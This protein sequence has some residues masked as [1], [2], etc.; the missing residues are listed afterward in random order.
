MSNQELAYTI[1]CNGK[2]L[3]DSFQLVS[4]SVQLGLN[5]IGKA[6]LAFNAGSMDK[7]TFDEIDTDAFKPG[8][9][10][11]LDVGE[12]NRLKTLFEGVITEVGIRIT[13]DARSQMVVE[14]RD[15]LYAATLTRR[16]RIFTQKKDC[17]I[18]KEL[19]STYAAVAVDNTSYQHPELVQY[20]C[21]DW[22]FARRRAD[23][24]GMYIT[25]QGKNIVVA[26]PK[27][28]DPSVLTV[29]HGV[30]LIS[31]DVKLSGSHLAAKY[32]AVS[33]NPDT[34]T[35]DKAS[36]SE[37]TLNQQG[38]LS[39]TVIAAADNLLLQ[40]DAPIPSAALQAWAD[41]RALLAGL[42][43]YQG[44]FECYGA[45]EAKPGCLIELKGL[46]QRFNGQVFAGTVYHTIQNNEWTTQ[47]GVG[48]PVDDEVCEKK[49]TDAFA[50]E[51]AGLHIAT[52]KQLQGDPANGYRIQITLPWLTGNE[53]NL[54][55]RFATLY[56]TA[57]SDTF[58]LPEPGDEVVVGFIDS[59]PA[60]PVVLGCLP[61][62]K[63]KPSAEYDAKNNRKALVTRSKLTVEFDEEKKSIAVYTPAGNRI[64]L[65]DSDK[66]ICLS[67]Q[68]NNAI[69]MNSNGITL[70]SAKDIQLKAQG[71]LTA[72][73]TG[74]AKLTTKANLALEGMT[75]KGNAKTQ[76]ELKGTVKAE[77]SASAQTI[78]KGAMVMIN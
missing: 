74:D 9:T 60:Y 26:S 12:V 48:I 46:G 10:L 64:E 16:N 61:G 13:P 77:L 70:K 18:I 14:C 62:S 45:A 54:W 6:M 35:L 49:H 43:R 41:S 20:Y 57:G 33:W 2:K 67:D 31:F 25:T 24:C 38:N 30:N 22:E 42:T 68:H 19:F 34:Q 21:S 36:A 7:Q 11:R 29:T 17:E 52:V 5:R 1:Y 72:D 32:E 3:D 15:V 44:T 23:A 65:N 27:L 56:A 55:A 75:I 53:Q 39:P 76:L 71:Q 58:F 63:H 78:I 69:S 73:A 51:I 66:S 59:Q 40:T 37:P 47:V 8:N 4:A 28:S 50:P